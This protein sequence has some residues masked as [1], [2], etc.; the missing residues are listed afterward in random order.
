MRLITINRLTGL[1]PTGFIAYSSIKPNFQMS[2][3]QETISKQGFKCKI[4]N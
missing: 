3:F 4:S 2:K 1:F